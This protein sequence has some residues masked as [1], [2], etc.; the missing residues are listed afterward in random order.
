MQINPKNYP[1][2][3]A[4]DIEKVLREFKKLAAQNSDLIKEI[5]SESC[6]V[7]L[8]D[9]DHKDF[10]FLINQPHQ[11]RGKSH[12]HLVYHPQNQMSFDQ[13]NYD[14]EISE[15][16]NHF[17]T[18]I[19]ILKAY[20]RI[21]LTEEDQFTKQYEDEF[22]QEFEIVDKDAETNP[23]EHRQQEALYKLLTY[24][25]VQLIAIENKDSEI[26][27]IIAETN[28]LKNNI[29][30]LTKKR[31]IERLARIFAK[32]K[33]N[34]L[35]LFLDIIDVAKKEAIKKALYGGIDELTSLFP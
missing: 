14:G 27:K 25:E 23:F 11:T 9:S 3:L 2:V 21:T 32:I 29:Q 30:N 12:F 15:M 17:N 34:G 10:I 28:D 7:Y 35:K 16:A 6:L 13:T 8:Q 26:D 33:K 19:G 4:Q 24:V 18:W 1:L 20:E 31:V 22:Y 5:D